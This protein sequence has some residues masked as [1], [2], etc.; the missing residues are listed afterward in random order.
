MRNAELLADAPRIIDGIERAARPIGNFIAVAEELHR[1]ADD[2]IS[3]LDQQ[4]S[5]DGRIDAARHGDKNTL[6]H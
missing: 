6:L 4:R 2:V 3:L 5:G 1:R